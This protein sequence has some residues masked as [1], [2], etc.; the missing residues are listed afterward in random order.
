MSDPD[1]GY[2]VQK[3]IETALIVRR[4]KFDIRQWVLVTDWN[5][6]TIY[7]YD[8]C[9]VRFCASDY[10]LAGGTTG[11]ERF[12][13]AHLPR[14]LRRLNSTLVSNSPLSPP[15]SELYVSRVQHV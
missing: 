10:T 15:M 6:L 4:R 8:T 11:G 1:D 7:F 13:L 2:I 14:A 9:Y 3:Y 12:P 5:P